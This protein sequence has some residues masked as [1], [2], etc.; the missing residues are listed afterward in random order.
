MGFNPH[1]VVTRI[2]HGHGA[3]HTAHINK[4]QAFLSLLLLYSS[5]VPFENHIQF[6]DFLGGMKR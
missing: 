2:K 6:K 5:I 3:W 1:E 4:C